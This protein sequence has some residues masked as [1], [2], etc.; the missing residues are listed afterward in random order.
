MQNKR[1]FE[2]DNMKEYFMKDMT[3]HERWVISR[4]ELSVYLGNCDADFED[5]GSFIG[6]VFFF[7]F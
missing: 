2:K 3:L 7:L 5:I 1:W 6:F 4:A